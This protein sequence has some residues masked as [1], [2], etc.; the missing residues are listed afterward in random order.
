MKAVAVNNFGPPQVFQVMELPEP[1]LKPGHVLIK[2]AASSVNPIDFKIRSG[3]VKGLAPDFPAILHGDVAGIVAA[4]GA[5][6]TAFKPGDEV[7]GCAGGVKGLGGALA[8]Y[9]LADADLVALKPA[10]LSMAEAA[11]LP[12]VAITAWLGLFDRARLEA[13][14][15]I[16]VHAATGGVGHIALQLAKQAGAKVFTTGSSEEKLRIGQELG[17]DVAPMALYHIWR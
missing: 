9:M 10:S 2:V 1:E 16:L 12:L 15:T 6:V 4:V 13:G 11:A 7:Y 3:A 17:A 5:G 8:D 14:Q